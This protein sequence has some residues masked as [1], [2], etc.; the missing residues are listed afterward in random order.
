MQRPY[1]FLLIPA[2][3]AFGQEPLTLRDA[4]SSALR[5][6]KS[7]AAIEAGA[8]VADA[9][10]LQAQSG[11]L[12]RVT[13]SEAY[14]RS[15]NPVF[16]FS[17]LLTQHRF[18][19]QNFGIDSL[20]RPDSLNNFQSQLSGEQAIYDGGLTRSAMRSAE[21]GRAMSKEDRRRAEMELTAYVIRA[22]YSVL[23]GA[24]SLNTAKSAVK[25]AQA[26]LRRA[27]SVREA[28]MSTDAD[29]LSIRVHLA[30]VREQ[31]IRATADLDVARATL[32]DAM[33]LPL[34]TPHALATRL[35][36]G[37]PPANPLNE[38]ERTATESR[39]ELRQSLLATKLAAEQGHVAR[40]ARLPQIGFRAMFEADRQRFVTWGGANWMAGV[41]M[42]WN[43]FDGFA[44]KSQIAE[45]KYAGE[46][47]TA[48]TERAASAVKLDVRRAWAGVESSQQRIEVA[49]AAMAEAD[50]SLR[51]TK[52][53]YEGGL[54]NVTDLLRNETAV[55]ESKTRYLAA[56]HDQRIA[57]AM[58]QL[59]AGS[60]TADSE[61]LK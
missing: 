23:L 28:G 27:D 46:R 32:N 13:Y 6:N 58:L 48:Q 1:L 54:G 40:A 30:A 15:N 33:G 50:E 51:I 16:V 36:P 29:V 61:V 17:S 45:A 2:L 11:R 21:L 20:N 25:S 4:V 41:S 10:L 53:R 38:L 57:L 55:L 42:K 34:D 56:V 19:P 24:E 37:V 12:P 31:E 18:G 44:A 60:L 39:P 52:N 49:K 22:Y 35:E 5:Q 9:R 14:A 7:I 59:A 26:D 3:C 43:L 8:K 47:A